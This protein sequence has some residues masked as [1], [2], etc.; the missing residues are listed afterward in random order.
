[1]KIIT[2]YTGTKNVTA[3]ADQGLHQGIFGTGNYILDVRNKFAATLTDANTVTLQDGEGVM[4]GVHFRIDPG[5]S[6]SVTIQSGTSG[7]QRTDIICARY[8]KNA[9]TGVEAV[10]LVVIPGTPSTGNPVPPSYIEGDILAGDTE[11]DFPLYY[12]YL[13]GLTPNISRE[14]HIRPVPESIETLFSLSSSASVGAG[15]QYDHVLEVESGVWILDISFRMTFA[16]GT[17]AASEYVS[18]NGPFSMQI[19]VGGTSAEVDAHACGLFGQSSTA[20]TIVNG[21][22]KAATLQSLTIKGIRIA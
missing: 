3:N 16:S 7:Y 2:G 20:V 6:E 10:N 11:A 21:T 8:T 12:V 4:Q 17:F 14:A 1:M 18:L 19:N 5:T 13:N 22:S 9:V 15:G